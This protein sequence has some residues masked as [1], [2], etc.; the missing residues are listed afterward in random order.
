[1]EQT[2]GSQRFCNSS[3]GWKNRIGAGEGGVSLANSC[4][5]EVALDSSNG[6]G[7]N[8]FEVS[9]AQSLCCCERCMEGSSVEGMILLR[10]RTR[11]AEK[12]SALVIQHLRGCEQ[13]VGRKCEQLKP[14]L[15]SHQQNLSGL[16]G[17]GY[18]FFTRTKVNK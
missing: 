3:T 16:C 14:F 13:N 6:K 2:L 11:A 18:Y 1:M 5:C 10:E 4:K 17:K 12:V 7:W 15:W 8:S 9:G